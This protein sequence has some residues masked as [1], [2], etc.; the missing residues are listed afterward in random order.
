[1]FFPSLGVNEMGG[2]IPSVET[3]LDE[4]ATQPM[5]LVGAVEKRTNM[6]VLIESTAGVLEG[7]PLVGLH[8]LTFAQRA[9]GQ[10]HGRAVSRF[11]REV[12]R[13]RASIEGAL[14]TCT[15]VISMIT[16][17]EYLTAGVRG[18]QAAPGHDGRW[19]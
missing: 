3:I 18:S 2:F 13:A 8:I 7:L 5:L 11:T 14:S 6:T 4:R 16:L 19:R 1:M 12:R 10:I 9:A 15:I 17:G